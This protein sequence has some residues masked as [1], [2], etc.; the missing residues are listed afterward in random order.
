ME[1]SLGFVTGFLD[2]AR[3]DFVDFALFKAV[4]RPK[5]PE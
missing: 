2:F 5:I 3:N 1:S 4:S